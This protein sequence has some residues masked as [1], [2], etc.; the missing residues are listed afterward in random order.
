MDVV[1][2][3][4]DDPTLVQTDFGVPVVD[5][6]GREHAKA[7]VAMLVVVPGEEVHPKL[8]GVLEAAEFSGKVRPGQRQLHFPISDN[9][10]SPF[11]VLETPGG[12][13]RLASAFRLGFRFA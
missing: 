12:G 6:G 11:C 10:A 4:Q 3:V 13:A 8:S 9:Q 2:R 1:G 5:L 7:A